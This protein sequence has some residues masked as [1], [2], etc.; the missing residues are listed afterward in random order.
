MKKI[1]LLLAMVVMIM[2]FAFSVS[3]ETEGYYTYK[4]ENGEATITDVS[5]SISG[6]MNIP[7]TLG[8]YPVTSIGDHAFD[9]CTKLTSITIPD[10]VT[11]IGSL[12]FVGCYSVTEI[13]VDEN[14]V[15]YLSDNFGV[16]FNKDK[17]LLIQYPVGSKR[18]TYPIPV[19]V[20]T[21]EDYA[22][23]GCNDLTDI[24][25]PNGV[26]KIGAN[27]FCSCSTLT[28]ITI[29]DSVITIG[30][31]AI[32]YCNFLRS[33]TI[34]DGVTTIG[35][36]AFLECFG[37]LDVYYKGTEDDWKKINIYTKNDYLT[38]ATIHYGSFV[39]ENAIGHCGD[40]VYWNL[41][42]T[43][44]LEIFGTGKMH[45][46][47]TF[48]PPW[49]EYSEKYIKE[50]NVEYG[51]TSIGNG[52]FSGCHSATYIRLPNS[53]TYIGGCA[54]LECYGL[55]KMEN[56]VIPNSV[57]SFS[58]YA[59]DR[60]QIKKITIPESVIDID[61]AA[62]FDCYV[63]S[64]EVSS[65][66]PNY[67]SENGVLYN[68]DKTS[69][70][71]YP[72]KR[73]YT[74][75]I[76][77]DSLTTIESYAFCGMIGGRVVLPESVNTIKSNAFY[78]VSSSFSLTVPS[79]VINIEEDA[80]LGIYYPINVYFGSYAE[81]YVKENNISYN[82]ITP[83]GILSNGLTWEVTDNSLTIRGN[84]TSI[85]SFERGKAPWSKYANQIE[86]I[87]IFASNIKTI[88]SYAF[89]GL[90]DVDSIAIGSESLSH[91]MKYAFHGINLDINISFVGTETQ[92]KN[93]SI[94]YGND[95]LIGSDVRCSGTESTVSK[96]HISVPSKDIDEE[97]FF[98][99]H[100][101][102]AKDTTLVNMLDE[103]SF[104]SNVVIKKRILNAYYA[105]EII[106]DVGEALTFKFDDLTINADY[107][108]MY[109][110]DM[111]LALNS[112]EKFGDL[113]L[114]VSE[115]Y[116]D[117]SRI[118]MDLL[119]T[120]DELDED[121]DKNFI[122]EM[123][124]FFSGKNFEL[125]T[126]AAEK[127]GKV[128]KDRY[129]NNKNT[130]SS[131]FEGLSTANSV[132]DIVFKSADVVNSFSNIYNA[133]VISKA[134]H[135]VNS[136]FF[137]VC[138]EASQHLP[139]KDYQ[140]WFLNAV[141]EAENS[142][143][144]NFDV[145]FDTTLTLIEEVA[146]ISYE[147]ISQNMVQAVVYPVIGKLLGITS[148]QF[149][150]AT[151]VYNV[152][153]GILDACF[154]HDQAAEAYK[155]INYITPLEKALQI[156]VNS[157]RSDLIYSD[158]KDNN[159]AL[160]YDMAYK[161]LRETNMYLY[162]SAY[163]YADIKD[164]KDD[165]EKATLY[166][167]RWNILR[168]H[169]KEY[170]DEYTMFSA[171][172]PVDVYV[173]D[174]RGQL[175]TSIVNEEIIKYSSNITVMNSGGNKI[176]AYP[177]EL[178]YS[179]VVK[180]REEGTMDYSISKGT[181]DVKL[182]YY[183]SYDIPLSKNKEFSITVPTEEATEDDYKLN[184]EETK[185]DFDY[186]C[187]YTCETHSYS[188]WVDEGESK[189]RIC[190]AC[191][192]VEQ[193]VN[194]LHNFGTIK[195][196]SIVP[197]CTNSGHTKNICSACGTTLND[198]EDVNALGHDKSKLIKKTDATCIEQGFTTYTCS[199]GDTYTADE[200]PALGHTDSEWIIDTD[201][202]CLADGSKHIE[203]TVCE[204]ILKTEPIAKLPHNYSSVVT[205]ATCEKGGYTTYTCT[206]G[207]T[208]TGDKTPAKGHDYAEGA[209]KNC[210]ESKT[211]N[212]SCNCHKGGFIGLIW[213][214]L[215]FF[216]KLFGM[217][218]VCSCGVEHY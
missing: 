155:T 86:S 43:G 163:K 146:V 95:T 202:T 76:L 128:L 167:H 69:L 152:T 80:F 154:K 115:Y 164:Y 177:S 184:T 92:W 56:L 211:E 195:A 37:I 12:A 176:I 2:I 171:H 93:I 99:E 139:Y 149:N 50:I 119:K 78:G 114:S 175:V 120:S 30:N 215:R 44:T 213:K 24:V 68:K 122:E 45:D 186:D 133:Y 108:E 67:S 178:E 25:I 23:Y 53:I 10:S 126:G 38:N 216:Y 87:Y 174:S 168:C 170:G 11:V 27:A 142:D 188:E 4:V 111:I 180:A 173:Y 59:F 83:N 193:E 89:Y 35:E 77:C 131:I 172:C 204:E 117:V 159:I 79:S 203:C 39:P 166:K 48:Q 98:E 16:L 19:S 110:A 206:C 182:I 190:S 158:K 118:L 6:D 14:N 105:W 85:P 217:N 20:T 49:Q 28:S 112:N 51:V 46:F 135:D 121:L 33:V 210:G 132:L 160:K 5:A 145:V 100:L 125:S 134:F 113:D 153:Y 194:C 91:V 185:V 161:M 191:G 84:S 63:E 34:G 29:P 9:Y 208:Y 96:D 8:G 90:N 165:L 1:G 169:Y 55:A 64:F 201:S 74:N 212:C 52:A 205:E 15:N 207:D 70:I 150:I 60:F 138:R 129:E 179:F 17:T 31:E 21:I 40:N 73:T 148:G 94:D 82:L 7:S 181:A 101:K 151:L 81:S 123:Q 41:D 36:G 141:E 62:F 143:L 189:S 75:T 157:R 106:G 104:H 209:C 144:G 140:K 61:S 18:E 137:A 32:S 54:F 214:I 22:F 218:K 102:F 107:Y 147:T 42:D 197:T 66:N 130:I 156:V 199:C 136:D 187:N 65:D 116:K 97:T 200:V 57:K 127:L 26:T 58:P 109:L 103:Y 71:R 72:I 192:Y 124:E 198:G 88:G 47:S 162:E 183:K 196:Y 3:A 13:T